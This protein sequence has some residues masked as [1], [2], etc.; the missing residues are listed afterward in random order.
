MLTSIIIAYLITGALKT[1]NTIRSYVTAFELFYPMSL[2][3]FL[4]TFC[5]ETVLWLPA[6]LYTWHLSVKL[7]KSKKK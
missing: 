6:S 5:F 4:F 7:N 2:P 1:A 3:K